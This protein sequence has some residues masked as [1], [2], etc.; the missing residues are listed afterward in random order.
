MHLWTLNAIHN[1]CH[2]T[3]QDIDIPPAPCGPP[4]WEAYCF[5]QVILRPYNTLQY[6]KFTPASSYIVI[7]EILHAYISSVRSYILIACILQPECFK[8]GCLLPSRKQ[9]QPSIWWVS[10]DPGVSGNHV[11]SVKIQMSLHYVQNK[12]RPCVTKRCQNDT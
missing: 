9:L 6:C 11:K 1:F 8:V 3:R 4:G 12:K 7:F 5:K 2:I 10:S